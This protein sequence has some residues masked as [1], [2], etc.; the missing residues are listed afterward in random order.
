MNRMTYIIYAI[1]V[2]LMATGL[3]HSIG[4]GGSSGGGSYRSWGNSTGFSTGSGGGWGG[5]G[6]K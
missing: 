2:T 5:G 1:A 4:S 6:H 3:N